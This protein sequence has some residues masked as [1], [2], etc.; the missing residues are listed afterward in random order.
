M[1]Q[2]LT[3]DKAISIAALAHNG[4]LDKGGK[5]YIL[6]SLRVMMAMKSEEDMIIAVLHDVV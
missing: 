3:L 6:H 2:T 4:Q 1:M 5:P